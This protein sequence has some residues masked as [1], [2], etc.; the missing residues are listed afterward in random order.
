MLRTVLTLPWPLVLLRQLQ[1]QGHFCVRLPCLLPSPPLLS[2]PFP[3]PLLALPSASP[4]LSTLG[5]GPLC[6]M[7][8]PPRTG[9][10]LRSPI[11][12]DSLLYPG[13]HWGHLWEGQTLT[14]ISLL[15]QLRGRVGNKQQKGW[16]WQECKNKEKDLE[17]ERKGRK[18]RR[19]LEAS[20]H[21]SGASEFWV[22]P[23]SQL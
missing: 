10:S 12:A 1:G 14:I 2:L 22:E 16:E 17:V 9:S 8:H 13:Q 21:L 3:Q 18:M 6:P 7:S 4:A 19:E 23:S 20:H 5:G 11:M 15:C